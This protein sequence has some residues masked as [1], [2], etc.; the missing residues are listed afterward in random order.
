[1]QRQASSIALLTVTAAALLAGCSNDRGSVAQAQAAIQI[2]A[3]AKPAPAKVEA[4]PPAAATHADLVARGQQLV[5]LGGCGH[6]HTPMAF[7]PKL[8][9]PMPQLERLLSGHP[10]GAPAPQGKPGE[11][12]QAVIGPTFTSFRLPFGVVYA[13]NL[14]PDAETGLGAWTADDFIAVMRSGHRRNNGRAILPP[15]PWQNLA[16]QPDSE[17]RAIFAY[18]QSIPKISNRVPAAEVP[19]QVIDGISRSYEATKHMAH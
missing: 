5:S 2:A 11:H 14:T 1:M 15:M 3:N 17:L 10:A 13:A 12:D 6:C 18:L 16:S 19:Q 9:M 7:D 8:G 4:A